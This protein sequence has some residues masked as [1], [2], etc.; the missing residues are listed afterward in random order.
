[1]MKLNE[2]RVFIT[3]ILNEKYIHSFSYELSKSDFNLSS[4]IYQSNN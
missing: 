3:L 4:L 2:V 1:M